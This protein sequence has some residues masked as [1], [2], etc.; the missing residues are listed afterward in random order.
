MSKSRSAWERSTAILVSV[1]NFGSSSTPL[2]RG[3]RFPRTGWS[4]IR[5]RGEPER[6]SLAQ[7]AQRA[8]LAAALTPTVQ[9]RLQALAVL[10]CAQ[11]LN[12]PAALRR[13]A[14]AH[15][16]QLTRVADPRRAVQRA[17]AVLAPPQAHVE[18][19]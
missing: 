14:Q 10:D 3:S 13:G 16:V 7:P 19:A 11:D 6:G 8:G 18:L 9:R 5:V 4:V 15:Q 12:A 17:I 2:R 1:R